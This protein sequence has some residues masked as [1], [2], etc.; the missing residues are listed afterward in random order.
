MVNMVSFE[1]TWS[2]PQASA[3]ARLLNVPGEE[4]GISTHIVTT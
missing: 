3:P 1:A 4:E 2:L